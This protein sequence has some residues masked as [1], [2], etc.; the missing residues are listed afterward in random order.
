[1]SKQY[2]LNLQL[3][4]SLEEAQD[5]SSF[6]KED[7]KDLYRSLLKELM[8]IV[9]TESFP[10]EIGPQQ[11]MEKAQKKLNDLMTYIRSYRRHQAR[12]DLCHLLRGQLDELLTVESEFQ[13]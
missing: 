3:P 5:V 11:R 8:E 2:K 12:E 6:N 13:R 10:P 9:A 7:L 1:M 4:L